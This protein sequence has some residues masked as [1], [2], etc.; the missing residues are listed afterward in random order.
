M[1]EIEQDDDVAAMLDEALRLLDH[2]LG[3][4]D[5][6]RRRLVEGRGDDLALHR[7]LHVGDLFRALVDQRARSGSISGWLTAIDERDV[8]QEHGLAGA[9]RR[10]DEGALAL[11]ERCHQIDDRAASESLEV[12]ISSSILKRSSGIERRQIVEMDLVA[13]LLGVFEIDRVDLEQREIAL[14]VLRA[15]G[16]SPRRCRRCAGAKRRICEGET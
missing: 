7:A 10:G 12:G 11:A 15:C 3:D 4:G 5:M 1:I 14:A 8:L 2:H 16:S 9:R 6:A 13:R